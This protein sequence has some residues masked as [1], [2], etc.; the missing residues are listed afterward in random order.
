MR[1][2]RVV[3]EN[4]KPLVIAEI[5]INHEGS[6]KKAVEMVYD[7][8]KVGA[9]CVKFQYHL[10]D[11][12]MS[13]SAKKTIP[14]N[15]DVSIYEVISSCTLN[16]EEHRRLKNIVES[17]GMIYLATPFS[18]EAMDKLLE[19]DIKLV[20]IGSGECN[21]RPLIEYVA[22]YGIPMIVSTGMNDIDSIK[23]TVNAIEK[24]GTDYCLLHC[25]SLYPTP[26]KHVRLGGI[27]ELS[28]NFKNAVIG[29]SD[30]SIGNYTSFAA[31]PLGA[32]II[33]KH[34]TSSKEWPGPD[35]EISIDPEELEDLICGSNAIFESLGGSK[36]VLPQEKPTIDFAYASVVAIKDISRGETLTKE[37]I[38]VKRPG[39]GDYLADDYESLLGK[40]AKNDIVKDEQ[41]RKSDV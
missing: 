32:R 19:L 8:Y 10:P 16:H 36:N 28:E 18:R 13:K 37:N 2:F 4:N 27:K 6:F 15:T 41:V 9:E 22:S 21:N 29:L 25:T 12:E 26:Y 14:M 40:V 3:S 1:E 17:L 30:H 34:F 31:I 23:K 39:T 20:K 33:E 5:G 35:I 11:L 24:Y 38:W 7:A